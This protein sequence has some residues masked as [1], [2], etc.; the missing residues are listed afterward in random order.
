MAKKG[1]REIR[2]IED[3]ME[4]GDAFFEA[5][6]YQEAVD[7]YLEA[8]MKDTGNV[9]LNMK[10][11]EAY[12]KL[13]NYLEAKQTFE[14]INRIKPD[15]ILVRSYLHRINVNEIVEKGDRYRENK[16]FKEALKTYYKAYKIDS[17]N[18]A[19]LFGTA[20]V[21]FE[22]KEIEKAINFFDKILDMDSLYDEEYKY[23][24]NDIAINLGKQSLHD[25]AIGLYEKAI[26]LDPE[27]G[28][29]FYNLAKSYIRKEDCPKAKELLKKALEIDSTFKEANDLLKKLS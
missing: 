9:P 28:V 27:D 10:I 3:P 26:A 12:L 19:A 22:K 17:R 7:C 2:A 29:L 16:E 1:T 11:G 5:R 6:K 24:L 21:Y 20:M 15:N 4:R 23:V 14:E 13:G 25:K 8:L 18:V